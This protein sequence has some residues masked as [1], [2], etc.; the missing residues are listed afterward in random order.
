MRQFKVTVNGKIFDV[1]VEDLG[2]KGAPIGVAPV[3]KTPVP[4]ATPTPA[5]APSQPALASGPGVIT[6]PMA[7]KILSVAVKV[8]DT[9]KSGDVLV[10]LEAMKMETNVNAG[11]EGTVQEVMVAAGDMVEAGAPL[12]RCE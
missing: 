9:V 11:S 6:S 1:E 4:V 7:A 10:V 12:V 8:G 5:A 3:K 2:A